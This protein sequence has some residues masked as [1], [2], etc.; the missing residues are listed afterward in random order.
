[1]SDYI[2]FPHLNLQ[3]SVNPVAF[4]LF[5]FS[6]RWYGILIALAFLLAF[7]YF[8]SRSKQF[9]IDPDKFSDI[10]IF[11]LLGGVIG[12]RA[13]YV[14]FSGDG[15]GSF[16]KFA[17]GEGL[18]GLAIYGGLIGGVLIGAI[19][20]KIRHVRVLPALDLASIGFLIGQAIGRWGN[21]FNMEAFGSN[22]DLPWGMTSSTISSYLSL[23][24]EELNELGVAVTPSAPVHPT[25]L[26]ESLW[27]LLGF[28]L[29]HFLSKKRRYDGEVFLWYSAWYGLGRT[30]IEG[31]RTDSLMLGRIRVSQLLAALLTLAALTILLVI[32]FR[33]RKSGS[34]DYLAC[35]VKTDGWQEECRLAEEKEAARKEKK[36]RKKTGETPKEDEKDEQDH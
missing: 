32:R 16:F 31:L 5:G 12:A 28:I 30:L 2:S 27:C 7:C 18:R 29:L 14:I 4:T 8:I 1:M 33:I 6:V 9:G 24:R 36:S 26:Y 15:I 3:F 19:A 10:V 23:H 21:F 22:T 20:C 13:Y 35:Y 25:F 17:E 34:P 11:A